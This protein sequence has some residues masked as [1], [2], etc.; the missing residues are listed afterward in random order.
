MKI[1]YDDVDGVGVGG[2][3]WSTKVYADSPS[4]FG[5][6]LHSSDSQGIDEDLSNFQLVPTISQWTPLIG[7][8]VGNMW[9]NARRLYDEYQTKERLCLHVMAGTINVNIAGSGSPFR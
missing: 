9:E 7:V 5:N 4:T 3:S 6:L 1:G 8:P 2:S